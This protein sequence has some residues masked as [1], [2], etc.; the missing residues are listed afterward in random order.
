[1]YF[2][3]TYSSTCLISREATLHWKS[4]A[5]QNLPKSPLHQIKSKYDLLLLWT[6]IVLSLL[7]GI[8]TTQDIYVTE[9]RPCA[10]YCSEDFHIHPHLEGDETETWDLFPFT[11]DEMR[12]KK[13]KYLE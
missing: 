4:Q 1:M 10:K 11:G 9:H 6:L 5:S 7:L 2:Y 3:Y 8:S 12:L 13:V